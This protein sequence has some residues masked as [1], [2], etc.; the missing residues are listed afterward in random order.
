MLW[1]SYGQLMHLLA[2]T[3]SPI[4]NRIIKNKIKN[5]NFQ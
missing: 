2:L 5:N 4:S 1:A 3:P